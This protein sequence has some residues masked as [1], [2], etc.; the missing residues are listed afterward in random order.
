MPF[1]ILYLSIALYNIKYH[2]VI[3]KLKDDLMANTPAN[4]NSGTLIFVAS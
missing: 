2:A 4:R 1:T 3:L